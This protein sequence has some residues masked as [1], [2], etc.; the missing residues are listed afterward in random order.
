MGDLVLVKHGTVNAKWSEI[1][2]ISIQ[3]TRE[4]APKL[5]LNWLIN[6]ENQKKLQ[7][8]PR[9]V[10]KCKMMQWKLLQ[11]HHQL[12]KMHQR[13]NTEKLKF[14]FSRKNCQKTKKEKLTH[15][16]SVLISSKIFNL[17][18]Q[19]QRKKKKTDHQFMKTRKK[20]LSTIL[21]KKAKKVNSIG[22]L[23]KMPKMNLQC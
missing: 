10:L 13:T 2:L 8:R 6:S 9:H 11:N 20:K 5:L 19:P 22:L 1:V 4:W 12:W 21:K 3:I 16:I 15:L 18:V 23:M 17:L 14:H 7:H